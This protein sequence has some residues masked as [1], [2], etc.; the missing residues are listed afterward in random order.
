M[1]ANYN[2]ILELRKKLQDRHTE[3]NGEKKTNIDKALNILENFSSI[4]TCEELEALQKSIKK[5]IESDYAR[6]N[7]QLGSSL[8]KYTFGQ[9]LN[10]ISDIIDA[11]LA[12]LPPV[13]KTEI[14]PAGNHGNGLRDQLKNLIEG[15]DPSSIAPNELIT[16][17]QSQSIE[18]SGFTDRLED[19][20]YTQSNLREQLE[21]LLE[22]LI[23]FELIDNPYISRGE[24]GLTMSLNSWKRS[25]NHPYLRIGLVHEGNEI[26][27][28]ENQEVK[29]ILNIFNGNKEN[30][31]SLFQLLAKAILTEKAIIINSK[32]RIA[33]AIKNLIV[34]QVQKRIKQII[35]GIYE[36]NKGKSET[37]LVN[38]LNRLF[39]SLGKLPVSQ[40]Y[41][42]QKVDVIKK[43]IDSHPA[44]LTFFARLAA[45]PVGEIPPP[46]KYSYPSGSSSAFFDALVNKPNTNE[47]KEMLKPTIDKVIDALIADISIR[48]GESG[49]KVQML[50][51]IKEKS[52]HVNEQTFIKFL[53]LIK[54]VCN[55]RR[56]PFADF[57]YEIFFGCFGCKIPKSLD[58]F[59][60][61]TQNLEQAKNLDN[62]EI[63]E[64]NDV[65]AALVVLVRT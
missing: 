34:E 51:A 23:D 53:S 31:K 63:H 10:K 14:N 24:D 42:D 6:H 27:Y 40:V 62:E 60:S 19:L 22:D 8:T 28:K 58:K 4:K 25:T 1:S 11:A 35:K 55:I 30:E 37:E 41:R 21:S 36:A 2:S 50:Q 64:L 3:S 12:N 57:L 32:D 47:K 43:L 29:E 9:D 13:V 54:A 15:L 16:L 48:T 17:F 38:D 49:D 39:T 46:V 26:S 45:V 61:E 65:N 52:Q 5:L 59:N 56:N 33:V 7:S 18:N 44:S 20:I